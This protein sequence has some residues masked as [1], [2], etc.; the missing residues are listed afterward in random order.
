MTLDLTA[1]PL[2]DG[3]NTVR[4]SVSVGHL[5]VRV[6][7]DVALQVDADARLGNAEVLGDK[8]DIHGRANDVYTS[9]GYEQAPQRLKLD[10]SVGIGQIEVV[11]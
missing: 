6:P 5:L 11:D 1:T 8:L 2:H 3:E 10:L 7:K 9:P 4:A